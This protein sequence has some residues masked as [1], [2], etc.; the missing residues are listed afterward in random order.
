MKYNR[1]QVL[2]K[3]LIFQEV[4]IVIEQLYSYIVTAMITEYNKINQT[5][6]KETE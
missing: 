5:K 3:H 2:Q 4:E 6:R 1:G